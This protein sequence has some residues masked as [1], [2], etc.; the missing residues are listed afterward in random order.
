M[1]TLWLVK[2]KQV[3]HLAGK[4]ALFEKQHTRRFLDHVLKEERSIYTSP[5]GYL[6]LASLPNIRTLKNIVF[7]HVGTIQ[8]LR[9]YKGKEKIEMLLDPNQYS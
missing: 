3:L 1:T 5:Q 7:K 6:Y 2:Y 9:S 4:F 8:S